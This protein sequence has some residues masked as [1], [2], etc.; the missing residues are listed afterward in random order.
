[1]APYFGYSRADKRHGRRE[2][3]TASMVVLLLRSYRQRG[4]HV[5]Q[6][7][8]FF[9]TAVDTLTAIPLLSDALRSRLPAE[10]AVVVSPVR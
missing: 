4:L 1:M 3:V 6:I 10:G 8:G 9:H 5:A 7:E 2:P